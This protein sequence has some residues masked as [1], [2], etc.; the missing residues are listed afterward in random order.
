MGCAFLFAFCFVVTAWVLAFFHTERFEGDHGQEE[1]TVPLVASMRKCLR[2]R[3]FRMLLISDVVEATGSECTFVVLPFVTEYL[4]MPQCHGYGAPAM[5]VSKLASVYIVVRLLAIPFWKWVATS[6][7]KRTANLI[8]NWCL[9]A[10]TLALANFG[11]GRVPTA[12]FLCAVWGWCWGGHFILESM[13]A[14]VI[15]YDEFITSERREGQFEVFHEL[16]PK[17][18]EVPSRCVPFM[19]LASV[20]FVPKTVAGYDGQQN[21]DVKLWLVLFFSTIPAFCILIGFFV[22]LYYPINKENHAQVL[23]LIQDRKAKYAH[24]GLRFDPHCTQVEDIDPIHGQR[25]IP[26]HAH[27]ASIDIADRDSICNDLDNFSGWELSWIGQGTMRSALMYVIVAES[28]GFLVLS[29]IGLLVIFAGWED[30]NSELAADGE[31]NSMSPLGMVLAGVSSAAVAFNLIRVDP[32]LRLQKDKAFT[33]IVANLADYTHPST[34]PDLIGGD[35]GVA[36][37]KDP[38]ELLDKPELGHTGEGSQGS[39]TGERV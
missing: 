6:Q 7:E 15:D 20:G 14:D 25:N 11:E 21:D 31:T 27:A 24:K 29:G 17:F 9:A 33:Y 32:A 23:Q 37:D 19:V 26:P 34:K 30:M 16:I 10:S 35:V 22:I 3:A 1:R 12:F 38:E 5:M 2:N 8:Y 13:M 36:V 4:L 28:L 39:Q 18:V